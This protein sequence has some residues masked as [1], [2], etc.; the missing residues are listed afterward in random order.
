MRD[1]DDRELEEERNDVT[2]LGNMN[3][4]F[5]NLTKNVAMGGTGATSSKRTAAAQPAAAVEQP[6]QG[7]SMEVLGG[8]VQEHQQKDEQNA[9]DA[10]LEQQ[11]QRHGQQQQQMHDQ[12]ELVALHSDQQQHTA[13]CDGIAPQA[14]VQPHPAGKNKQ[15]Q[16]QQQ[17]QQPHA[18]PNVD[19]VP[20]T[21][22]AA[23]VSGKR[24]NTDD[25]IA[26]ARERYLARKRQQQG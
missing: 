9:D 16:D 25:A 23:A 6:V 26:A 2:K 22:E 1:C 21:A 13:P 7:A 8:P 24:K 11:Q 4:F 14:G 17:E 19:A 18:T 5:T 3:N 10:I 20:Q 12:S 15:Q